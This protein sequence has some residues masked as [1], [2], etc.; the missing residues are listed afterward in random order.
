[1]VGLFPHIPEKAKIA[2]DAQVVD[3]GT[4]TL[5]KVSYL[6]ITNSIITCSSSVL[7]LGI[8]EK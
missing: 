1:M 2:T 6:I 7:P 5:K 3:I 8:Q 4:I